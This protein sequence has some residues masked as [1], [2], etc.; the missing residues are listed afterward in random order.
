VALD[1]PR[2][3][4]VMR[5]DIALD[6]QSRE[7]FL[8]EARA[9]AQLHHPNIVAVVDFGTEGDIQYLVMEYVESANLAE[10]LGRIPVAGRLGD[11]A[12][13]QWITDVGAGLDHAHAAG[14]VHRD[15]KP[16]NVLVRTADGRAMLTDFGIGRV[17]ADPEPT[18]P[19]HS[20]ATHAYLSPEQC[21]GSSDPTGACDV[22]AFA[23][24]LYEI[25]TGEPPFGRDA[26]AV[27]GHLIG[28]VP[29]LRQRAPDLPE[30]L[31]AALAIGLAKAPGDRHRTAGELAAAC[32][33]AVPERPAAPEQPEA[34]IQAAP[35]WTPPLTP[36]IDEPAPVEPT[37]GWSL[38]MPSLPVS[39]L[40]RPRLDVVAAAAAVLLG[41]AVLA[42]FVRAVTPV[43]GPQAAPPVTS[44]PPVAR[45][46][47]IPTPVH[48][49][50]GSTFRVSGLQLR[51]LAVESSTAPASVPVEAA[52]RFVLVSV[53]YRAGAA[54]T[55]TS[56]YDWVV[57]DDSGHQYAPVV[58]GIGRPL[59]ERR[60]GANQ[61]A[62]GQIG[63]VVPRSAR[64]L[65]LNFDAQFGDGAAQVPLPLG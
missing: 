6:Q 29:P 2:A 23:A 53:Q 38:Q 61:S 7:R 5:G 19:G 56:P 27:S 62:N 47:A 30:A 51:V 11:P 31:E 16:A 50:L 39:S 46:P 9:A 20:A 48:G 12:V 49:T 4:K 17:Q 18:A 45:A 13:R 8:R 15:L 43:Q 36:V 14:V 3:V 58:D 21:E 10:H 54:A 59:P 26:A 37:R 42:A 57:S 1:I 44:A 32:L 64:G 28:P 25:A 63:F 60:L 65:V 40:P 41:V 35:A 33:R 22:Y 52:E 34:T 24:V 55:V